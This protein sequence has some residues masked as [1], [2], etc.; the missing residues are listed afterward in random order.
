MPE[1]PRM[2]VIDD[3]RK[4]AQAVAVRLRAAGFDVQFASDGEE[5]LAAVIEQ[6]PDAIVLDIRMPKLDGLGVLAKLREQERTRRIPAVVLSASAV[7]ESKALD[8]GAFCF[9]P[10]P[11]D[12][13][14]LLAAI[15]MA[16]KQHATSS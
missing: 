2:L 12:P 3:D 4:I 6:L 10:K 9:L 16:L 5:G 8:A 14:A 7:D 11:Y 1:K 13:Q 15:D